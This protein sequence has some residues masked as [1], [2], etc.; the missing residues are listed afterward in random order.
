MLLTAALFFLLCVVELAVGA[1]ATTDPDSEVELVPPLENTEVKS[2]AEND[3]TV[4]VVV[5]PSYDEYDQESFGF[6]ELPS[7]AGSFG[8]FGGELEKVKKI[9]LSSLFGSENDDPSISVSS[10]VE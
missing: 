8:G 3:A 1:P 2:E 10:S 4:V 7:I 6:G 9:D 5:G